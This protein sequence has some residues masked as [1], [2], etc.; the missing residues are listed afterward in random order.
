M[1]IPIKWLRV[2]SCIYTKYHSESSISLFHGVFSFQIAVKF[3]FFL[4][5]FGPNTRKAAADRGEKKIFCNFFFIVIDESHILEHTHNKRLC[6]ISGF[7]TALFMV[8]SFL[9]LPIFSKEKGEKTYTSLEETP[10]V[11]FFS[12]SSALEE[13]KGKNVSSQPKKRYVHTA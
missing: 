8:I 12:S 4:F 7:L 10:F 6:V 9:Q 5:L 2:L 3:Y 1:L 13:T 11:I